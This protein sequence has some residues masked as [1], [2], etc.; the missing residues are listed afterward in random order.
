MFL[1]GLGRCANSAPTKRSPAKPIAFEFAR[2]GN[3]SDSPG[4]HNERHKTVPGQVS[5]ARLTVDLLAAT[6]SERS[7]AGR[8]YSTMWAR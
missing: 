2:T 3:L 1:V 7:Y 8:F 4:S 5:F 6:A